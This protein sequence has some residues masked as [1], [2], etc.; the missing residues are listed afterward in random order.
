MVAIETG[1]LGGMFYLILFLMPF[2][3]FILKWKTYIHQPYVMAS[4]ALIFAISIVSL[5]DYYTWYVTGRVWHWLAW[6]IFSLALQKAN[7]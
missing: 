2:V 7:E 5:F 1:V 6:G 4:L 3:L